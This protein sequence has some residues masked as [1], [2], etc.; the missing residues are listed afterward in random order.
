MA[1]DK[2]DFEKEVEEIDYT[3]TKKDT[4]PMRMYPEDIKEQIKTKL[5]FDKRCSHIL[6]KDMALIFTIIDEVMK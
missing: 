3:P 1:A 2:F 4:I 6:V 5:I